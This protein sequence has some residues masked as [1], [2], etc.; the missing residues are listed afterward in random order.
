M[1]DKKFRI[2]IVDDEEKTRN[3]IKL[4]INWDEIGCEIS[5][6]A[7]G[8]QEALDI[9][10]ELE[11][12][13]I[14]TDIEMPY[15]NGLE[16]SKNI[17]QRYP[18]M[19]V[20]ILT[21]HEN[22]SYAKESIRIGI[23]EY[24]VKPIK[25]EQLKNSVLKIKEQ[26][27]KEEEGYE[28]YKALIENNLDNLRNIYINDAIFEEKSTDFIKS[29]ASLYHLAFDFESTEKSVA[30]IVFSDDE[31]KAEVRNLVMHLELEKIIDGCFPE[32]NK[33]LL[34]TDYYGRSALLM[35]ESKAEIYIG[36]KRISEILGMKNNK[37][38]IGVGN[39]VGAWK[40]VKSS[41]QNALEA[42]KHKFIY[43]NNSIIYY[44]QLLLGEA[45]NKS[46]SEA[47]ISEICFCTKVGDT[48]KAL[49][50][51]NDLFQQYIGI[52][53][54][55]NARF[56]A[57]SCV[58][59]LMKVIGDLGFETNK[60]FHTSEVSFKH[61]VDMDNIPMLKNYITNLVNYM[62]D[63]IRDHRNSQ[64]RSIV[65]R[66]K[67]Y[68]EENYYDCGISLIRVAEKFYVNQSFLSRIFKQETGVNFVTYLTKIRIEKAIQL[69]N[70]GEYKIYEVAEQVG[71]PDANYFP[72]CFKK[73]TGMT[74][75]E[76][77]KS[78]Q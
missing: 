55:T 1:M 62:I 9:L 27:R 53:S 24:I 70:T 78:G 33:H 23:C 43:G 8:G 31:D 17:V 35:T 32:K 65:V 66:I 76:Y 19:K 51:I 16:L 18:H 15:M 44:E 42:V 63:S 30:V 2:M 54:L 73:I 57:V 5:G 40:E 34:Y 61:I 10:E 3:L 64:N 52:G 60:F 47:V 28:D 37:F 4:C 74:I 75:A 29:K 22:F 13:L 39:R 58:I 38:C 50:K 69:L 36:L 67:K 26:K 77:R 20:A 11:V 49:L 72:K 48:D 6:E 46:D 56:D 14:I 41:Y 25:R 12:D 7:E 21:A 68:L 71:I 45:G 59:Q